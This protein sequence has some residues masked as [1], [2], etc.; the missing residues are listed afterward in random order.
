MSSAIFCFVDEIESTFVLNDLIKVA[1][2][3]ENV[4]L[5]SIEE[6]DGKEHL[7]ANI[8]VFESFMKWE[9]FR[10][11]DIIMK[12]P[13]SILG[14]YFSECMALKRIFLKPMKL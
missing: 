8:Q 4:F 5:F 7:P 12:N 11:R 3:Y 14:I 1:A 10:P 6:L 13:F 2:K 9:N